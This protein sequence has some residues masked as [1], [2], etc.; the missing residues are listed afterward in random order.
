[1]KNKKQF[2]ILKKDVSQ[3]HLKERIKAKK[4][5]HMKRKSNLALLN[6]VSTP[7]K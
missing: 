2:V 4:K 7:A 1:M 3:N 6:V 5:S